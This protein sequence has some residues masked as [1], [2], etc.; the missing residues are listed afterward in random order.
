MALFTKCRFCEPST[1]PLCE[2]CSGEGYV[3]LS[4]ADLAALCMGDP[5]VR[6][7]VLKAASALAR[8]DAET[9]ARAYASGGPSGYLGSA[10]AAGAAAVWLDSVAEY[11]LLSVRPLAREDE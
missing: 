5:E 2:E 3:A 6:W 11:P 7:R 9:Y 10:S 8:A 1:Q 4:E